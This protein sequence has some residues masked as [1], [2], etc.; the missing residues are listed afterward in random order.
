MQEEESYALDGE[1][2]SIVHQTTQHA[3]TPGK[4]QV[5]NFLPEDDLFTPRQRLPPWAMKESL[6]LLEEPV[7]LRRPHALN[8]ACRWKL[9]SPV[10]K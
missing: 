7:E 1:E 10:F 2:E 9:A 8:V 3:D 6:N 5:R 4:N